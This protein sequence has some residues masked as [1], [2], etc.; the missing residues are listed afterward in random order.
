MDSQETRVYAYIQKYGFITRQ[1]AMLDLGVANLP[2]RIHNLRNDGVDIIT[3][4]V[5]AKNRFGE[6]CKYAEYHI[7]KEG[8]HSRS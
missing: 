3:V 4:M 6:K 5:E 8:E 1:S 2:A 7:N